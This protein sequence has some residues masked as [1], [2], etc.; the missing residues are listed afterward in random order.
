MVDE[1]P[2]ILWEG[3]IQGCVLDKKKFWKPRTK[4]MQGALI[5]VTPGV[6]KLE[7][8]VQFGK[9]VDKRSIPSNEDI[10]LSNITFAK[11]QPGSKDFNFFCQCMR[12]NEEEEDELTV[13]LFQTGTEDGR[14][15]WL[16][17][18]V[19]FMKRKVVFNPTCYFK[20]AV[21]KVNLEEGTKLFGEYILRTTKD[22]IEFMIAEN[23]P[24]VKFTHEEVA[25]IKILQDTSLEG[26][27]HVFDLIMTGTGSKHHQHIV[28][29]SKGGFL[30]LAYLQRGNTKLVEDI[31]ELRDFAHSISSLPLSP[32]TK[33]MPP[34]PPKPDEGDKPPLPPR[35]SNDT[36]GAT[37]DYR[38]MR[39]SVDIGDSRMNPPLPPR[40]DTSPSSPS[41]PPRNMDWN[42]KGMTLPHK[43]RLK[44]RIS[45]LVPKPLP[46]PRTK[47]DIIDITGP[48]L[49]TKGDRRLTTREPM[50]TPDEMIQRQR[51]IPR[52]DLSLLAEGNSPPNKPHYIELEFEDRP[53]WDREV[54]TSPEDHGYATV[55]FPDA[56]YSSMETPITELVDENKFSNVLTDEG[57]YLKLENFDGNL[58]AGG[59]LTIIDKQDSP[60]DSPMCPNS[61]LLTPRETNSPVV[62]PRTYRQFLNH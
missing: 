46:V 9:I 6:L 32:I 30:L 34:I 39:G 2:D 22:E 41:F 24:G 45:D 58:D 50:P 20:V 14:Q 17:A 3:D 54:I 57:G 60:V 42:K 5:Q 61:P 51:P 33:R 62:P 31:L 26:G 7:M 4:Q 12:E 13:H 18:V 52:L 44:N 10:D 55:H 40:N 53:L 37:L 56:E 35:V 28:I 11:E 27:K 19:E 59:Y 8:S 49:P 21:Q 1:P 43:M 16:Q 23:I 29:T 15:S 25:S 38:K 36:R 47:L 48:T